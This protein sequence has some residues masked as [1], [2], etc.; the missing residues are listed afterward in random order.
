MRVQPN[1]KKYFFEIEKKR[2][3]GES[4]QKFLSQKP[5]LRQAIQHLPLCRLQRSGDRPADAGLHS[6]RK[7]NGDCGADGRLEYY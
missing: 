7:D 4:L 2:L 6:K 1:V 3:M 5:H